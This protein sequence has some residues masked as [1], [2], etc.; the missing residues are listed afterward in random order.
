MQVQG[1]PH[2]SKHSLNIVSWVPILLYPTPG[3]AEGHGI[4]ST[5]EE[6]A[7]R[8]SKETGGMLGEW[9]CMQKME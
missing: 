3:P 7:M 4:E 6:L 8:K 1:W 5:G 9:R 2:E